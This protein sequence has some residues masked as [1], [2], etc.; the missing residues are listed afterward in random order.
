MVS[1]PLLRLARLLVLSAALASATAARAACG[2]VLPPTSPIP[3]TGR[4]VTAADLIQMRDVGDTEG[5]SFADPSPFGVAPGGTRIAFYI[6]QPSVAE[7]A[8]CR[9]LVL[10][11][12][13]KKAPLRILDQGGENIL[14]DDP[15]FGL[16][17]KPGAPAVVTPV[18]SPDGRSIAYLR[19]D[20]GTTR[21]WV[22]DLDGAHARSV[23]PAG[24]DI[25]QLGWT[26]DGN[27]L[28]VTA[29]PGLAQSRDA[30]ETEGR[31]GWLFDSRFWPNIAARPMVPADATT[32]YSVIAIASGTMR[33]A[34][35][36]EAAGGQVQPAAG[37]PEPVA[38]QAGQR[39]FT[40]RE[41]PS[42]LSPGRLHAALAGGVE[43]ACPDPACTGGIVGLWWRRGAIYF[44]RRE[45]WDL[46]M[47][48]M[49]RW[50]PGQHSAT[51]LWGTTDVLRG[52]VQSA[53]GLICT[54]EN[55]T[56]PPSLVRLNSKS[57]RSESLVRLNP[58]FDAIKLPEVRRLRWKNDRGLAA[59]GDLVLPPDYRPGQRVP[60][61]VT[62]YHSLGFL[63][64]G[65]GDEYPIFLFAE[66]GMA[67][68][69]VERPPDIMHLA[70]QLSSWTDL[71][72]FRQKDWAERRSMLSALLKGVDLAIEQG[73]ADPARLGLTGLSDGAT[74]VSFALVNSHRFAAAAS[75]TCCI[76]PN[77]VT[78]YGGIGWSDFM[79]QTGYPPATRPDPSFWAPMSIAQNARTITTPL[80]LQSADS[81]YLLA[82]ETFEAL[83]ELKRPVELYVFP[84]ELHNKIEP[85]HRAAAFERS[86][87]W[88]DFWLRGHADPA[89]AKAAQYRRWDK[90]R[91]AQTPSAA[92]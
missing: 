49:Y 13:R 32:A 55:S 40:V 25:D 61:V 54:R 64:G 67:V 77:T 73:V 44:L 42:P 86:L 29:R 90:M 39:A 14:I 79:Q 51:R 66:R 33:P 9:A 30:I 62:Q 68:L 22:V 26:G 57:G 92:R 48:A 47:M 50:P 46:E 8:I 89:P 75:S 83:R 76:D 69:S 85:V 24:L 88:F 12:L 1:R 38:E 35:K 60:L 20:H 19:R 10:L 15:K 74:S 37:L 27:G 2:S 58:E 6:T 45:G 52:C 70:P 3:A 21:A 4:G 28:I 78:T 63:R 56:T 5:A 16:L 72:A 59:W 65:T 34:T 11:D 23:S 80:L 84:N 81:E 36:E 43:T 31:S 71:I 7:N 82:L 87:D 53:T 18:W 91:D 41:A 17:I